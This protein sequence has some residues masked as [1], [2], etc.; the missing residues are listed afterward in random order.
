MSKIIFSMKFRKIMSKIC[1]ENLQK[2]I[3]KINRFSVN[4]R[5][6]FVKSLI[7][8]KKAEKISKKFL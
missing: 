5:K 6:N 7:K 1:Q 2:F 8:C 4:F 3:M